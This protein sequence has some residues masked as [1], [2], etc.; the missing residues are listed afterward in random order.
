[1]SEKLAEYY[2]DNGVIPTRFGV[3][4]VDKEKFEMGLRKDQEP[5]ANERAEAQGMRVQE[6]F[7]G[8]PQKKEKTWAE[9]EKELQELAK[10]EP[11]AYKQALENL[12]H[13]RGAMTADGTR[14]PIS[15]STLL[16]E[17][18]RVLDFKNLAGA[19]AMPSPLG[20]GQIGKGD[21]TLRGMDILEKP[22]GGIAG[23][24]GVREDTKSGEKTKSV[25][26]SKRHVT[27][28]EAT[29][30]TILGTILGIGGALGI[31]AALKNS[32]PQETITPEPPIVAPGLDQTPAGAKPTVTPEG[33]LVITPNVPEAT[34]PAAVEPMKI[35]EGVQG[36][37][38]YQENWGGSADRNEGLII[39]NNNQAKLGNIVVPE[40]SPYF[41]DPEVRSWFMAKSIA[42]LSGASDEADFM[43]KIR[44][45]EIAKLKLNKFWD[46][47]QPVE[48]DTTAIVVVFEPKP[49]IPPS[50]IPQDYGSMIDQTGG[51]IALD[52]SLQKEPH[53]ALKI[54]IGEAGQIILHIGYDGEVDSDTGRPHDLQAD[55]DAKTAFS[56]A[57][58]ILAAC[59]GNQGDMTGVDASK[60]S[61]YFANSSAPTTIDNK[62]I[63]FTQNGVVT[64]DI[65]SQ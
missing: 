9:I 5:S 10:K 21:A 47:N 25:P 60:V 54:T 49:S 45:G 42:N 55:L 11:E 61:D 3:V 13:M 29:T 48:V 43:A 2:F 16:G 50:A 19:G 17:I 18:N 59:L 14:G 56:R 37:V 6:A 64:F 30:S 40:N 52:G 15:K 20:S 39:L 1:M 46:I 28:W 35:P 62:L 57:L 44:N 34:A 27:P 53:S 22:L 51:W 12:D 33:P 4:I 38:F 63:A 24:I 41:H 65:N 36:V 23:G 7:D 58:V 32:Q 31:N 8:V 26:L